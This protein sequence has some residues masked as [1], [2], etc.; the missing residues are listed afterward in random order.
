MFRIAVDTGGTFSDVVLTDQD[1]R[2][3]WVNK[4][5]TTPERVFSGIAEALTVS[6][7]EL[8][9]TLYELLAATA[10]FTYGTTFS[11]NAIITGDTARTAFLTT[12]EHPDTLGASG[13]RQD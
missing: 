3:L 12:A 8:N 11:T 13:G 10:V 1:T 9:K 5:L 6:A 7:G 4:A 2:A